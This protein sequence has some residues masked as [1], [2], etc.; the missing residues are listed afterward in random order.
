MK[1]F[2]LLILMLSAVF[3]LFA[4]QAQALQ[5]TL[6]DLAGNS[7]TVVDQGVGDLDPLLGSVVWLGPLGVW[8]V[9]VSTGLS[10]PI[11][12]SS[13]YARMDLN[14]I[15]SS[16]AA[17]QMLLILEDTGFGPL[18]GQDESG[19]TLTNSIGGTT[20][21]TVTATGELVDTDN[22]SHLVLNNDGNPMQGNGGSSFADDSSEFVNAFSGEFDLKEIILIV[23]E[24]AGSTSFDKELTAAVPEPATM[25]LSGLGLL[26][27]GVYL[28][29]RR[30]KKA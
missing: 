1:K 20:Q 22:N 30:T 7:I 24:V 18:P 23:H 8:N 13:S 28:R 27:L 25:L 26:G 19:L 4:V 11:L 6:D 14:S 9:N 2:L 12:G 3:L 10:Q 5:L 17:G 21:G 16:T 29:R 15:H